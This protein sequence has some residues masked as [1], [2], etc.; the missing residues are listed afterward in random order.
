MS[1]YLIVDAR[2][3]DPEP[4]EEYKRLVK[5]IFEA[6]GGKYLVRGGAPEVIEGDWDPERILVMEFASRQAIR[7]LF[8]SPE[9]APVKAIRHRSAK[10]NIII[11]D[12]YK[13][14]D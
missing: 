12:A 4:Y 13:P 7:D 2:C 1:V 9:Y 3:T 5:P 6:H 8:A 14:G 10:A 11:C